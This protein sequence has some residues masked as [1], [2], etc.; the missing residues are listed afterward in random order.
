SNETKQPV[1]ST[2]PANGCLKGALIPVLQT[3]C[4]PTV[5]PRVLFPEY[6]A[7]YT[8]LINQRFLS[9]WRRN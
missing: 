4:S 3:G 7:F 5:P 9:R 8:S 1:T 2:I 6:A